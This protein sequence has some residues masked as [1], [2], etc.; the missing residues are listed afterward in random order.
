[1]GKL[2][3]RNTI[4][5]LNKDPKSMDLHQMAVARAT[6]AKV[7]PGS[8]HDFIKDRNRHKN[9]KGMDEAFQR[10]N[11]LAK[12]GTLGLW[13]DKFGHM[14]GMGPKK[15]LKESTD[16]SVVGGVS[17]KIDT[18]LEDFG[19]AAVASSVGAPIAP[20]G[21]GAL[22]IKSSYAKPQLVKDNCSNQDQGA[23]KKKC[24]SE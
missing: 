22:S 24:D 8:E 11:T 3:D 4:L 7:A 5:S 18:L 16:F 21:G 15:N 2:L 1:M 17:N 10:L 23:E 9:V 12:N 19:G 20:F 13:Q 14:Y 6:N